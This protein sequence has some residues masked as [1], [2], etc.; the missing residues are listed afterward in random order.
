[1]DRASASEAGNVGSTPAERK[2]IKSPALQRG[3]YILL[4]AHQLLGVRRESKAGAMFLFARIK[5][6]KPFAQGKNREARPGGF[7]RQ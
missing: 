1:M 5:R 6:V 2:Y 7:L 4:G 3:F